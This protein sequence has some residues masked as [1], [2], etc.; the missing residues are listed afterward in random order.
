[1]NLTKKLL[2]AGS[3]LQTQLLALELLRSLLDISPKLL[4]YTEC[5]R[6]GNEVFG[7][8]ADQLLDLLLKEGF[9]Q[10]AFHQF[11]PK[12]SSEAF[13]LSQ[14]AH[15]ALKENMNDF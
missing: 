6:L 1:M 9:V 12:V 3:D 15:Q 5:R 11:L 2:I 14:R 4:H 7:R 8:E 13:T 10:K